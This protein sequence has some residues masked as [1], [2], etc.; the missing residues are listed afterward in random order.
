MI[1]QQEDRQR[2]PVIPLMTPST[3]QSARKVENEEEAA[4]IAEAEASEGVDESRRDD[5]S[6]G[7]EAVGESGDQVAKKK[8][9]WKTAVVCFS[10]L[11]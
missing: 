3:T 6:M 9:M 11:F 1:T 10:I 8:T 5:R 7:T 2:N 4:A